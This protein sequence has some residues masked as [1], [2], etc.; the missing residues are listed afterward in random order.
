M[1]ATLTGSGNATHLGLVSLAGTLQLTPDASN[2]TISHVT[3]AGVFTAADGDKINI[4]LEDGVMDLTTGLG[5]GKVRFIGGSGRF[6]AASGVTEF[7]VL[8]SP[9][10][11]FEVTIVG[12]IDY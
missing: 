9:T 8:Q 2:P 1:S 3:G 5:H 6:A 11:A 7:V 10:G 12:T 4:L